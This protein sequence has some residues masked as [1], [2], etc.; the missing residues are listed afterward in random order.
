MNRV[1]RLMGYMLLFQSRGLMR[2]QDF[3]EQFEISERTVYRDIQALSEVGVPIMAMPGE[4]YRLMEG[5]YLPPIMFSPKEARALYLAISMLIGWTVPGET[6]SAA[7]AALEKIR[8]VLP[9]VSLRQVEA[10]QAVTQFYTMPGFAIDFDD[11]TFLTLQEAIHQRR[12]VHLRYHALHSNEVTERDVEPT[13]LVFLDKA[14]LLSGY[15]RLRQEMRSFRLDRIDR[16]TLQEEE[17]K[18]PP[19]ERNWPRTSERLTIVVRFEASI[20]RWVQERQHFTFNA[21]ATAQLNRVEQPDS[22]LM[23]YQPRTFDQIEGWLLSWGDKLEVIEP[24]ALRRHMAA[25]A[26]R[27]LERHQT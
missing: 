21:E 13:A 4:G 18:Q 3:A 1:D 25:I 7:Q 6:R 14:W 20:V 23:V 26:A 9:T 5:Y 24:V 10:L 2:A 8:S 17:F 19:E 12:V 15:C 22:G 27:F 16:L 11:P